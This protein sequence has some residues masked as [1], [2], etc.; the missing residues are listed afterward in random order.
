MKKFL[1][2]LA[3]LIVVAGAIPV[4]AD[5]LLPSTG[6]SVENGWSIYMNDSAR[7]AGALVLFQG[8]A[9]VVKSPGI[10]Q[11]VDRIQ[12]IKPIDIEADRSYKLKFEASAEKAGRLVVGYCRNEAP[13]TFYASASVDLEPGEKGYECTLE[14]NRGKS[15]DDPRSLRL[16]FGAFED[17]TVS[18]SNVTFEE[19]K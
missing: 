4:S 13:F 14:V 17:A 18:I 9:A 2:P 8:G 1:K 3:M 15:Y 16:F 12:I 7:E 5:N 10:Q 11:S 6:I 19:V